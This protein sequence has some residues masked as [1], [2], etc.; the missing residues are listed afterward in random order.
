MEENQNKHKPKMFFKQT[1]FGFLRG[2]YILTPA[3]LV[4]ELLWR[5]SFRVPFLLAV[6]LLRYLYYGFCFGC[7]TVCYFRPKATPVVALTESA[8]NIVLLFA[9]YMIAYYNAIFAVAETG[10][11]PE[12]LTVKGTLSFAVPVT[13]CVASFYHCQDIVNRT[14]KEKN[15]S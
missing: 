12:I 9:G 5:V 3:F 8:T 4:L 2:Y 13:V 7:G 6:P 10:N 14:L 15:K 1:T 11:I